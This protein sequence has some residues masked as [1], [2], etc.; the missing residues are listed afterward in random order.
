MSPGGSRKALVL[1]AALGSCCL[2]PVAEPTD[3]QI[4]G[5]LYPP[6]AQNAA[7]P[8]LVCMP[9]LADT[10]WTR[11]TGCAADAGRPAVGSGDGGEQPDGGSDGGYGS[12][13]CSIEGKRWIAGDSQPGN[14]C[15]VCAPAMDA[16]H[17]SNAYLGTPCANGYCAAGV[18]VNGCLIGGVPVPHGF[19]PNDS[20]RC[21]NPGQTPTAWVPSFMAG[22]SLNTPGPGKI[23]IV[24]EF[25]RVDIVVVTLGAPPTWVL[26]RAQGAGRFEGPVTVVVPDQITPLSSLIGDINGDGIPDLVSC[27]GALITLLGTGDGV[28]S[29]RF[30]AYEGESQACALVDLR[31][32]G[33]PDVVLG[34][35]SL[36]V[37]LNAGDG[38]FGPEVLYSYGITGQR[39]ATG[40][41][42]GDGFQDVASDGTV[43]FGD[44]LGGFPNTTTIGYT[45]LLSAADFNGD[46][47]SDLAVDTGYWVTVY[48]GDRSGTFSSTEQTPRNQGSLFPPSVAADFNGDGFPDLLLSGQDGDELFLGEGNGHFRPAA[49]VMAGPQT[50]SSQFQAGDL[51]GD[52]RIDAVTD[53]CVGGDDGG[54][55][56]WTLWF[57]NCP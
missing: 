11:L 48:L 28:F 18:C 22:G 6:G 24:K 16:N 42:N 23:F 30:S 44:G 40:D 13:F 36:G 32:L 33:K 4:G 46:G 55:P 39:V 41:F 29:S 15:N 38:S 57:N 43:L 21:C 2:K 10:S 31:K 8:C 14:A 52:G 35:T 47:V 26:F 7:D 56:C 12:G 25:G 54:A 51:N 1:A 53:G 27:A 49:N 3:C 34:G 20:G 19:D 5:S 45:A 17:W 37:V 9:G 50:P